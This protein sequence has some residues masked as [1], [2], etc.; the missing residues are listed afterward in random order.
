[1]NQRNEYTYQS[2]TSFKKHIRKFI[3]PQSDMGKENNTS[4]VLKSCKSLKEKDDVF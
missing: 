1:M 2:S 3:Q 4:K